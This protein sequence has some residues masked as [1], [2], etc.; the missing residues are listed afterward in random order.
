MFPMKKA[1][2]QS[3]A[4]AILNTIS[5]LLLVGTAVSFALNTVI[6]LRINEANEDRYNLT[7]YA[8]LFMD[9]SADLTND[10]RAYAATGDKLYYD[11]YWEEINT[12][13]SREQGL[14]GMREIGI[15]EAEQALIDNMSAL[16]TG[17]E[18]LENEAMNHVAQGDCPSA[19]QEVYGQTY[20]DTTQRIEQLRSEF[21]ATLERRTQ[22]DVNRLAR[23]C[24]GVNIL[25][26]VVVAASILLQVASVLYSRRRVIRP[27]LAIER[28]MAEIA[29]GNLSS[30]FSLEPD[31]SE[32]GVLVDSIHRTK[33]T[34]K[35]YIGDISLKLSNMA[36]G[37]MDQR[38]DLEYVGDFL[39]IQN[40]LNTILN[41][42]NATLGEIG[43]TSERVFQGSAQV[44]QGA[45]GLAQGAT[46]QASA[47]EELSATIN[48]LSNRMDRVAESAESA[49]E[50]TDQ[51]AGVL[52]LCN[53]KMSEL[54]SAM[55]EISG[56]ASEIAKVIDTIESIAFQTNILAL[57]A[58]VEAARAGSAGKGFAV[59]ADEVRALAN[60]SQEAS[61]STEELITRSLNAVQHGT[62]IAAETAKTLMNVVEGAKQSAAHV[63]EI[64]LNSQ[65]QAE[66]LKQLTEGVNQIADVVQTNSATSE[67]SAAAA[68]E[69][70]DQATRMQQLMDEFR[71]RQQ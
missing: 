58:A 30:Q 28:E 31:T 12:I 62:A 50:I 66:A 23:M 24:I 47:V 57:N 53:E 46:E 2:K 33:R 61:G 40:A 13:Q 56:A 41:S 25:V 32:I 10:V 37:N 69:L 67:E 6:S 71:L 35:Q 54:V 17:L 49:K 19:V 63:D 38:M 43:A 55:N 21:I 8:N 20:S 70:S 48:D 15:T 16:S 52:N 36:K 59:V 34:L 7:S 64:A 60:K 9:G 45:Q 11:R 14:A 39:P 4:M 29:R 65:Q 68:H 51:S 18:S 22:E 44:S 3:A 5:I 1:M 42:L 27:V 26:A